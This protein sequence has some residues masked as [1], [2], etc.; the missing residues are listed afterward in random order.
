MSDKGYSAPVTTPVH[1]E[2]NTAS[3]TSDTGIYK[4]ISNQPAPLHNYL[5][6]ADPLIP[7]SLHRIREKLRSSIPDAPKYHPI[8]HQH[9]DVVDG[10]IVRTPYITLGELT[11]KDPRSLPYPKWCSTT[12]KNEYG[13]TED[14]TIFTKEEWEAFTIT[15][16][17]SIQFRH[18]DLVKKEELKSQPKVK[19]EKAGRP[20]F[21]NNKEY[22]TL[23]EVVIPTETYKSYR[24]NLTRIDYHPKTKMIKTTK[25]LHC[26]DTHRA[27]ASSFVTQH[28]VKA[29]NSP[30]T[31]AG[32]SVHIPHFDRFKGDKDDYYQ[33]QSD[34]FDAEIL[35]EGSD[36]CD[37][38]ITNPIGDDDFIGDHLMKLKAIVE[39]MR[40]EIDKCY[41]GCSQKHTYSNNKNG[42]AHAHLMVNRAI[43]PGFQK[44][45]T[46]VYMANCKGASRN[47]IHFSN[48]KN[49]NNELPFETPVQNTIE[50]AFRYFNKNLFPTPTTEKEAISLK[51]FESAMWNSSR[52]PDYTPVYKL[53]MRGPIARRVKKSM[54][55]EPKS[56]VN[57]YELVELTKS[58]GNVET[59]FDVAFD[60]LPKRKVR[61]LVNH[62]LNDC[63]E[64]FEFYHN[65]GIT[66]PVEMV[67]AHWKAQFA[68]SINRR[69][70][71]K[72]EI[73]EL[74]KTIRQMNIF[75]QHIYEIHYL[76]LIC[77]GHTKLEAMKKAYDRTFDTK[78]DKKH[79]EWAASFSKLSGLETPDA[80][81][82]YVPLQIFRPKYIGPNVNIPPAAD[83]HNISI[84][85][86]SGDIVIPSINPIVIPYPFIGV[87]KNDC[88]CMESDAP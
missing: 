42:Y 69:I 76:N 80:F 61:K 10:V 2:N 44:Y 27:S 35:A 32:K 54:R 56:D 26:F 11:P 75:E 83:T 85:P 52:D 68:A 19:K 38:T 46:D 66:D 1:K 20:Y 45:L 41:K 36:V 72:A 49:P 47:G 79:I 43:S 65:K 40:D 3:R 58:S 81:H 29:F 12:I 16:Q 31:D 78:W 67:K 6:P 4:S 22:D 64:I 82:E 53:Y 77:S 34:R 21:A 50:G 87:Y 24:D 51:L 74:N 28:G 37:L 18:D 13:F 63:P 55:P 84:T 7:E 30:L 60:E 17:C 59:I 8:W 73:D 48:N 39:I 23:D 5:L 70:K 15:E 14:F 9:I 25:L 57:V 88:E 71:E 33:E 86:P 62:L